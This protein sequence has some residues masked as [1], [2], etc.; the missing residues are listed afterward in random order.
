M[1]AKDAGLK[2]SILH[3]RARNDSKSSGIQNLTS[4]LRVF[5]S[6]WME[7]IKRN[8]LSLKS[9]HPLC[10][11]LCSKTQIITRMKIIRPNDLLTVILI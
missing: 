2:E 10:N 9:N 5:L 3:Q 6:S 7:S 11:P 4:R 1:V 8:Q